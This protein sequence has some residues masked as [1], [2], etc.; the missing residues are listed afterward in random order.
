MV[1]KRCDGVG[2]AKP[3]LYKQPRGKLKK[4]VGAQF[5]NYPKILMMSENYLK[6]LEFWN[7]FTG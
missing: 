7:F 2:R 3:L 6:I 1:A 4:N 5:E